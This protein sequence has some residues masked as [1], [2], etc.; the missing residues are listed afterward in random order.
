MKPALLDILV[1]PRCKESLDLRTDAGDGIEVQEGT[2]RC[3]I[4]GR[5]YRITGGIPRFVDSG[6]YAASFGQQWQWFPRV[7]LDSHSGSTESARMLEATTGWTEADYRG[8][9]VLDAGV[10]AGRFAEV[11]ANKGG[12]VV[13]VDLSRAVDAAYE[14]IGRRPNVHLVQADIMAMPFREGTF[15]LA[16]SV[17]VLHHT[18]D[19]ERAFGRVAA[20]VRKGG[21]LAVYVY[22][23][24]G[25]NHQFSDAIRRVDDAA[26]APRAAR[27]VGACGSRLLPLSRARHPRAARHGL[28]DLT[29]SGL[30]VALARY[31]RLVLTEV[32]V[33]G[34]VPRRVPVV[35]VQRL[36]GH[37]ALRRADPHAR[38]EGGIAPGHVRHRRHR[39]AR[40]RG[41]GRRGAAQA[42]ARRA[43]PS[44][45]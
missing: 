39:Q 10:G 33:E 3:P 38:L 28:P 30:A 42:H 34:P 13:G 22:A 40:P 16:Y 21:A 14:N 32:P 20:V 15:D 8:R 45:P 5:N 25:P 44:R 23:R 2:L 35:P 41:D 12:E 37:R 36:P 1:C 31:V 17:G 29:A 19:P 11:V 43:A 26:A 18:P 27:G 6:S 24:Y 4:C 9:L 7:Q